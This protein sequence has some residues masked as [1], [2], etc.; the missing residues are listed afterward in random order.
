MSTKAKRSLFK[1]RF[2][3]NDIIL[4]G[5]ESKG[6][7]EYIHKRLKNRLKI[8]ISSTTRSLN[9]AVS[10]SISTAEALR[11]TKKF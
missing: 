3:N 4:L 11:Q 9:V 1:F 6:V 8:P 10:A 7:P 5:R 2:K